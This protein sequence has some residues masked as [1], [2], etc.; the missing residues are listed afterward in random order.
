MENSFHSWLFL[1]CWGPS[2]LKPAEA[3][4][5]EV[6]TEASFSCYSSDYIP[7]PTWVPSGTRTQLVFL[8][9]RA[10]LKAFLR[11]WASQLRQ[12]L[13]HDSQYQPIIKGYF[14]VFL[15]SSKP[16]PKVTRTSWTWAGISLGCPDSALCCLRLV[17]LQ[18]PDLQG[19]PL[20]GQRSSSHQDCWPGSQDKLDPPSDQLKHVL[21]DKDGGPS[22][23]CLFKPSVQSLLGWWNLYYRLG[24]VL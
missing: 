9:M 7:G 18:H 14:W 13:R 2:A 12:I 10:I 15:N 3:E 16:H 5:M 8:G 4:Y 23:K 1:L 24:K 17:G 11:N 6:H 22:V 20:G 21:P 19:C